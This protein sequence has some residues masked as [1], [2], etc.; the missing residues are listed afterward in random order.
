MSISANIILFIS[1]TPSVLKSYIYIVIVLSNLNVCY[2]DSDVNKPLFFKK[3]MASLYWKNF[4]KVI[5]AK[6]QSYI[7]N[8]TWVYRNAVFSQGVLTDR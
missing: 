6:F 8:D 2:D 1:I 5:Y 3:T 7:E 4:E